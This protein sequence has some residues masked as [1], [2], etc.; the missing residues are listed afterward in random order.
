[1]F[2]WGEIGFIRNFYYIHKKEVIFFLKCKT[3]ITNSKTHKFY[4]YV[5]LP[6]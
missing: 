3:F 2:F 5:L 4:L 1:M 6:P